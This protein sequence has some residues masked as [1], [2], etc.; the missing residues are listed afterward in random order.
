MMRRLKLIGV[1]FLAVIAAGCAAMQETRLAPN[2]VRLDV[3][4]PAAPLSRDATLRRAAELTL[5]SGYTAFRLSPIYALAF[6][7]FGVIVIMLHAGDPNAEG[8]FDAAEVIKTY[9]F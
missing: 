7:D 3:N 1:G 6:N 9:A 8:A 4:P 2:I 5:Q